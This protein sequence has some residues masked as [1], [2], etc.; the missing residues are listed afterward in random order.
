MAN[1]ALGMSRPRLPIVRGYGNVAPESFDEYYRRWPKRLRNFP[2]CV[3]EHW[4]YRHWPDFRDDW[5]NFDLEQFNFEPTTFSNDQVMA[6]GHFEDWFATLD[7]WGDEL[8][9]NKRRRSTWLATF[10]LENGTVPTPIIV[11]VDAAGIAH[12]K[13]GEMKSP[14]H[15]VEGHMRLAYLRG[16]IRHKYKK[17]RDS[18]AVWLLRMPN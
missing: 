6:I 10:M 8:F 2:R 5:S 11:A 4:V 14:T 16:M 3:V 9:T 7:Y 12:P 15:L 13:G 18:H 1:A 17:L